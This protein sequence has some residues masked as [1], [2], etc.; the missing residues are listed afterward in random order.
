MERKA[1]FITFEGP[2]G[3][4][5]STQI[6]LL[7]EYLESLGR[8]VLVTREPGGT[9]LAEDFRNIVKHYQGEEPL[10]PATELLLFEAART[11]HTN[12]VIAP[13]LKSGTI[14]LCDRFADSTEAYQGAGRSLDMDFLLKLN[15][16]AMAGCKPDLTL[17]FD[18]PIEVGMERARARVAHI[19][20]HNDRLEAEKMDFHQRVRDSFLAIA[21]RE[22]ERVKVLD[23]TQS[24]EELFAEVKGLVNN[25]LS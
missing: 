16:F 7:K 12:Y 6:K 2:E 4:G 11:Q 18:L 5:K 8:Q 1:L 23:A 22:P 14:V 9:P 21:R 19:A 3:A 20:D 25:A 15:N 17:L 13:A 24:I 10:F